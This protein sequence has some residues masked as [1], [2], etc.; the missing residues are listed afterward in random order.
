M[1]DRC[2][3]CGTTKNLTRDHIIPKWLYKRADKIIPGYSVTM[4]RVQTQKLCYWHNR[5]KG[6]SLDAST[7]LGK[8]F[9]IRLRE[10][11][12]IELAKHE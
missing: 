9:C 4:D 1:I 3:I 2:A 8:D 11:I 7:E 10:V 12:D 6:G 5:E